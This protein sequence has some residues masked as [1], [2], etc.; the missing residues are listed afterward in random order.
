MSIEEVIE[1]LEDTME[2]DIRNM[3]PKDRLGFWANLKE[4]QQPKIMRAPLAPDEDTDTNFT[5]EYAGTGNK[6]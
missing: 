6:S 3:S 4:F 2:E 5:I 1:L